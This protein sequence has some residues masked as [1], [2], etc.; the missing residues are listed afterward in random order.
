MSRITE[1]CMIKANIRHGITS[2]LTF[3]IRPVNGYPNIWVPVEQRVPE[4]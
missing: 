3:N 1:D 4:Q 2:K